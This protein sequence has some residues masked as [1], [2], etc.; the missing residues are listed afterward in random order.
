M[1]KKADPDEIEY[2]LTERELKYVNNAFDLNCPNEDELLGSENL[3]TAIRS[4][5]FEP[6]ADEIKK[7]IKKY[8]NKKGSINR[9]GFQRIMALK[10]SKS[11][12]TTDTV[13]KDEIS[14]VFS[15]LDLDKTGYIT[16]ENL[17]S[18][19]K[20]LNE[21]ITDEELQEM[22]AEA[23]QDGDSKIDKLEFQN[24]MKKTSLY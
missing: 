20:D 24:I 11:P 2:E 9:D 18:V 19:A 17:R 5:G 15:L 8:G 23:D 22:I 6:R 3:K 21:A 16:V 4:L 1:V 14:K 10:M 13:V 12:G 7:L